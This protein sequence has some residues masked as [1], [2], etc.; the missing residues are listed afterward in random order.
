MKPH[1]QEQPNFRYKFGSFEVDPQDTTPLKLLKDG[2]PW[3]IQ[4]KQFDL[5]VCFVRKPQELIGSEELI[6][7]V[8]DY[9][10]C[11]EDRV[12]TESRLTTLQQHISRLRKVIGNVIQGRKGGYYF[13]ERVTLEPSKSEEEGAFEGLI[14]P[15][16]LNAPETRK[17]EILFTILIGLS[18]LYLLTYWLAPGILPPLVQG[19]DP[20]FFVSVTQFVVIA[21]ALT[22][23]L[24]VFK[25]DERVFPE[26]RTKDL[27]LMEVSGYI[28]PVEWSA[29]K[30]SARVSLAQYLFYWQLFLAF[31]TLLYLLMIGS[32]L[33]L[34]PHVLDILR[35]VANLFNNFNSLA[36]ALCFVVLNQPTV[37]VKNDFPSNGTSVNRQLE[38]Y[39][40]F[41]IV[42]VALLQGTLVFLKLTERM[43]AESIEITMLATEIVGAFLGG[44]GL[45]LYV[46]RIQ[47]KFLGP[48]AWLPIV[49]YVYVGL[50]TLY[51]AVT[52]RENRLAAAM[53]IEVALVVKCLLFLFVIWL[54]KSGR[55]L[56]YFVRV[57]K[58]YEQVVPDWKKF[59]LNL[60]RHPKED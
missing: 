17:I 28:D 49:L 32:Y 4:P 6:K 33:G 60:D 37:Y 52:Q 13:K 8:W 7:A 19:L 57:K 18:L 48:S 21:A 31:W 59:F 3:K 40:T 47:S 30:E 14:F 51:V 39:G 55:F 10:P 29:A 23:S 56:F 25:Q 20:R 27:A 58:I 42:L 22:V 54:F 38:I 12:A 43:S 44:V 26:S 15:W 5:L 41:G 46:G 36:I 50:Q 24:S 2:R 9:D 1:H 35:V 45:A 16:I 34:P 11:P 53:I